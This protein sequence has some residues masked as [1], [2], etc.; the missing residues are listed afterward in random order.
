[1]PPVAV[2]VVDPPEQIV[3]LLPALIVGSGLTVTIT[4]AVLLQPP[5]AVP[6]TV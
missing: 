5:V 6:V 1:M 2:N 4:W 3:A